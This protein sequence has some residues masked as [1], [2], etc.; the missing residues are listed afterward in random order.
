MILGMK[1]IKKKYSSSVY[2]TYSQYSQYMLEPLTTELYVLGLR[3]EEWPTI[4]MV[5]ADILNK[6]SQTA[7]K[8]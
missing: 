7:D 6:Q 3:M 2:Y 8:G 1:H 5:A 4:W